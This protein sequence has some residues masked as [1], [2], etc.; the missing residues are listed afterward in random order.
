MFVGR[1]LR[2]IDRLPI[3]LDTEPF[4]AQARAVLDLAEAGK[5]TAYD[6]AYLELALRRDTELWT[7]DGALAL[8]ARRFGARTLVL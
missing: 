2:A 5:L 7:A 3:D 4:G 1:A 8:A 6:A